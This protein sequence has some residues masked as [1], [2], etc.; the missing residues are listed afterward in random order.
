MLGVSADDVDSH[1]AF[2]TK[3]E[4]NFPLLA[5]PGRSMIDAYGAWGTTTW[6][7]QEFTGVQRYSY[8]IDPEGKIAKVYLEVDP[9]THPE[10]ILNDLR[11]LQG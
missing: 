4:F 1:K 9:K 6:K 7:G 5:D 3:F 10:E 11:A 8:L 2:A